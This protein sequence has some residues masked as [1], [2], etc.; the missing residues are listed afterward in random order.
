MCLLGVRGTTKRLTPLFVLPADPA[1]HGH[2]A[3]DAGTQLSRLQLQQG[4]AEY[5]AGL[6]W[7]KRGIRRGCSPPWRAEG[8]HS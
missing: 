3:A 6:A 8:V 5:L 4:A 7:A 2:H 1:R